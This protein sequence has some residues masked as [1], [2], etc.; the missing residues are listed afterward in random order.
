MVT[1][2]IFILSNIRALVV[3][4]IRTNTFGHLAKKKQD[5]QI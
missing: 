3:N 4:L 5:I 2:Y 1:S